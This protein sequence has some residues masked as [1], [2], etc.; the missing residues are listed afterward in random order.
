MT[1]TYTNAK[2]AYDTYCGAREWKSVTGAP[3]PGFEQQE[4]QLQ[5]AWAVAAEAVARERDFQW[6]EKL[7]LVDNVAPEPEAVGHFLLELHRYDWNLSNVLEFHSAFNHPV[8]NAPTLSNKKQ[9]D[10]RVRLIEEELG[11][12][13]EALA[14]LDP[15]KVLDALCDLQYV[16][17]GA[18]A[19]LGFYQ[20]KRL[21]MAEVHRSNMTKLGLDGLPIIREDGKIIK[22]PNYTPPNFQ[23]V[24]VE[25]H[26]AG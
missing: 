6:W 19:S 8:N 11:E 15:V 12:L 18:F 23:R 7:C 17:D 9:N 26:F 16:V 4:P 24:L 5:S 20:V 3:L 10:L 22:G 14:A 13:K 1:E 2:L 21:A 25:Y